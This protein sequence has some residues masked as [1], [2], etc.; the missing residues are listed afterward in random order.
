MRSP[1]ALIFLFACGSDPAKTVDASPDGAPAAINGC[2]AAQ[3]VDRT[4]AAASRMITFGTDELYTPRCL[5][6]SVGQ[7]V[8]WSGSFEFHPLRPGIVGGAQVDPQPGNPVPSV[9]S[10]TSQVVTF[11]AAGAWAYY[12]TAHAPGMAGVVYVVP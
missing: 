6:I 1:L 12:C 3:A 9:N 8:T 10:G 7:S 2:Q 4:A 11:A 5:K